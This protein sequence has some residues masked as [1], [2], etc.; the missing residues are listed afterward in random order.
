[1]LHLHRDAVDELT[2]GEHVGEYNAGALARIERDHV[3]FPA[4]GDDAILAVVH[5][6]G[7]LRG[8][9]LDDDGLVADLALH[10]V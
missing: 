6:H 4:H 2:R 9:V 1:M 5:V 3:G 10:R 7:L 8:Y